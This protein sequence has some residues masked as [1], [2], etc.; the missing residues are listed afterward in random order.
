MSD[1]CEYCNDW[2]GKH[3]HTCGL[4]DNDADFNRAEISRLSSMNDRYSERA[5]KDA[6]ELARLRGEN[7]RLRAAIE[8]APH[9][10][11]CNLAGHACACWK[12]AA[13]AGKEN[14]G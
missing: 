2:V 10:G 14:E 13:L 4:V 12:R 7:E 8:A 1:W 5:G 3:E 6:T 11:L 9:A